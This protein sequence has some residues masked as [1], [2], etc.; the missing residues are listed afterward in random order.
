MNLYETHPL[1]ILPLQFIVTF[2]LVIY[3]VA[4]IGGW[5][6]LNRYYRTE[7]KMP[8]GSFLARGATF[9]YAVGYNNVIRLGSDAEGLYLSFWPRLAHP[10]LF[11]PWRDIEA[12]LPRRILFIRSQR[13]LLG[14]EA[15]IGMTLR[16]KDALRLLANAP[17]QFQQ[18]A[19]V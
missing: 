17:A 9:R 19:T 15:R 6:S 12:Q 11:I 10:P 14:R 13:L 7:R 1:L 18:A 2:I 3:L 8:A 5:T 4:L 16:E